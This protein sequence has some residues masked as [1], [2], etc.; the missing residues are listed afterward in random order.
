MGDNVGKA[1]MHKLKIL[2][3]QMTT[4]E[5]SNNTD[6]LTREE[7]IS[8]LK[9]QFELNGLTYNGT[10]SSLAKTYNS[11]DELVK[12][13]TVGWNLGNALENISISNPY[14]IGIYYK[15]AY[16]AW[17]A[18][19]NKSSKYFGGGA[20]V[21]V[22]STTGIA[23]I[24]W[25]ITSITSANYADT[26][27][28][29][30][31]QLSN[32]AIGDTTNSQLEYTITNATITK[33]GGTAQ[34]LT[35][36]NNTTQAITKNSAGV[37]ALYVPLVETGFTTMQD[38][39]GANI[40]LTITITEWLT[41]FAPVTKE[42][43]Y[44]SQ[45][46][47]VP[48]TKAALS[49]IKKKGFNLIR[50]PIS[51][52][53]HETNLVFETSWLN[54]IKEVVDWCMELDLFCIINT[55]HDDRVWL[56]PYADT[57][58]FNAT[59]VRFN[60]YWTTIAT[61]FKD[62]DHRLI[63]EAFNEMLDTTNSWSAPTQAEQTGLNTVAQNFVNTVRVIG[64]KN[65]DRVLSINTYGAM[66]THT[67]FVLPT[68]TVV[69]KLLVQVHLYD[70]QEFCWPVSL[71]TN[72]KTPTSIYNE[73]T[74]GVT[75]TNLFNNLWTKFVSQGIPVIIG[76]FAAYNKINTAERVKYATS[77]IT[78]AKSKGIKCVWWDDG[79][80]YTRT[81]DQIANGMIFNRKLL[82]WHN[83]DVANALVA[84]ANSVVESS[85]TIIPTAITLSSST[86][87]FTTSA[88]QTLVATKIP[89]TTTY[90]TEW[91]TS[92]MSIAQVSGGV[93]TPIQNGTATITAKLGSY[94]ATCT[95]T[96]TAFNSTTAINVT[97]S[98]VAFST[99][100]PNTLTV[101]L[102]PTTS[103][104]AT[105]WTSSVPNIAS[106]INN[107]IVP[108]SNGN[109]V[110]T[111][112]SNGIVDTCD[113]SVNIPNGSVKYYGSQVGIGNDFILPTGYNYFVVTNGGTYDLASRYLLISNEALR[114]GTTGDHI[115][116]KGQCISYKL[117]NGVWTFN[118]CRVAT[119]GFVYSYTCTILYTNHTLLKYNDSNVVSMAINY[120]Q[121]DY[122]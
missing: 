49:E 105:V 76:E 85:V 122:E 46:S 6:Y 115:R 110:I 53:Q 104:D 40:T 93:V 8:I 43:W 47:N 81:N 99:I 84:A 38:L 89:S 41:P 112:T 94:T 24:N 28:N 39:A 23:T 88:S 121:T 3:D 82:N 86:L 69:N 87:E 50:L 1:A 113:I 103:T 7:L 64:S 73:E 9:N 98:S 19:T 52:C 58:T 22:S 62:Y 66:C 114:S 31:I 116:E 4:I 29:I 27:G 102:T 20:A 101:A 71:V 18:L 54:R 78:K 48:I 13:I 25:T 68:D 5:Q 92:N 45:V 34:T 37:C 109:A 59:L 75:L 44:E 120:I 118:R 21:T 2:N 17:A 55:H 70:P 106:A 15:N 100:A 14:E 72:G 10:I 96:I 117:I 91:I 26:I 97:P 11:A 16:K 35:T 36:L 63:F 60:S 90:I 12:A 30:S 33:S 79:G 108:V 57:T 107:V 83:E 56:Y 111:A 119:V 65:A 80:L 77:Y 32:Y 42:V 67:Y 74:H 51:W 95:I 61:L